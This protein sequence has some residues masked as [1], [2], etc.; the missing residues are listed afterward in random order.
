LPILDITLTA[1]QPHVQL[2]DS[3]LAITKDEGYLSNSTKQAKV[4]ELQAQINQLVNQL[5]D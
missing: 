1:Q 4:K 2:V 5:Y 3:I